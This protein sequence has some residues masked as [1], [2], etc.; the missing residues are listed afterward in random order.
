MIVLAVALGAD[1][2]RLTNRERALWFDTSARG[3]NA[4]PF[5]R[6]LFELC[7]SVS[8]ASLTTKQKALCLG[9]IVRAAPALGARTLA[10]LRLRRHGGSP[11]VARTGTFHA[12]GGG[13]LKTSSVKAE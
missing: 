4:L 8:V 11:F 5:L 6:V 2:P 12:P 9:E 10:W 13:R 3:P 7:R 1:R